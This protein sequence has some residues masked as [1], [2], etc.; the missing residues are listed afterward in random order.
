[1][2]NNFTSTGENNTIGINIEFLSWKGNSFSSAVCR[3]FMLTM[4]SMQ[5]DR[6]RSSW[7]RWKY[8]QRHFVQSYLLDDYENDFIYL[9]NNEPK[10]T[11]RKETKLADIELNEPI[12]FN[13][14][15]WCVRFEKT[16]RTYECLSKSGEFPEDKKR[17]LFYHSVERERALA[18][19]VIVDSWIM[20]SRGVGCDYNQLK[21]LVV[22]MGAKKLV[23]Q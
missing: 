15:G 13:R 23:I 2:T 4:W 22:Q 11:L 12:A 8:S 10:E 3:K 7:T 6:P 14:F 18:A 9:N 19:V 17:K 16:L 21:I 5:H 1:M 20:N